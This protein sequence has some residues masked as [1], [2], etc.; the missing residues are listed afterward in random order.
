VYNCP[1]IQTNSSA[2]FMGV[3]ISLY[4]LLA[5]MKKEGGGAAARA[6][7]AECQALL[8]E[9]VSLDDLLQKADEYLCSP[10]MKQFADLSA[11]PH[12]N[13]LEQMELMLAA[14]AE[15]IA[16]N[17]NTKEIV[18]APL[19]RVV[20]QSTG[21]LMFHDSWAPE[22]PVAWLNHDIIAKCLNS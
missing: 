4:P 8:N 11:W 19:S 6:V 13:T 16:L 9:G 21:H 18:C 14:S 15:L 10:V 20:F 22:K 17:K 2:L 12:H 1:E 3:E 5:A 7:F